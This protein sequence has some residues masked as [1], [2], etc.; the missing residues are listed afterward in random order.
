MSDKPK[1]PEEPHAKFRALMEQ[2][3]IAMV[4][5][6]ETDDSLRARP[7]AAEFIPGDEAHVYFL[8]SRRSHKTEEIARNPHVNLNFARAGDFVSVS[9]R[10]DI[11]RDAELIDRLWSEAQRPWFPKGRK[12]PEICVFRVALDYGEYWDPP[13][14]AVSLAYGWTKA[15]LTG[16]DSDG[17]LGDRQQIGHPAQNP[18]II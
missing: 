11:T 17:D 14:A 3:R 4:T 5:T 1:L 6:V 12:D 10:A 9:G 18:S 7:M 15:I 8:T 13:S 16:R 2:I